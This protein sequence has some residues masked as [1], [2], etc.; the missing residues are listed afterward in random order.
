MENTRGARE[1]ERAKVAIPDRMDVFRRSSVAIIAESTMTRPFRGCCDSHIQ[2]HIYIAS[3]VR[4]YVIT[5]YR[6]EMYIPLVADV[7]TS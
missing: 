4:G 5:N 6:W 7:E 2:I 3:R 1:L